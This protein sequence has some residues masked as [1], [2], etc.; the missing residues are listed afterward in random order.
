M[1]TA[2]PCLWAVPV[3]ADDRPVTLDGVDA[4]ELAEL[5]AFT[6]DA[7]G[8]R[9]ADVIRVD[10]AAHLRR[11]ATRLHPAARVPDQ[12]DHTRA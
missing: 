11:W 12:S 3:A 2:E 4:V 7:L 5:L 6:A 1:S 9:G 10:L 8:W